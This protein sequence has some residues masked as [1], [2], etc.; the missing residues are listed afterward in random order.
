[1]GGAK[2]HPRIVFDKRFTILVG[3][4]TSRWLV[5]CMGDHLVRCEYATFKCPE[6]TKIPSINTFGSDIQG[7]QGDHVGVSYLL[8]EEMPGRY[9][10]K[11]VLPGFLV[12]MK[13]R[14]VLSRLADIMIELLHYSCDRNG[15]VQY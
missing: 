5:F 10:A 2:Y 1:M 6:N 3:L 15:S 14:Q 11:A 8:M 9:G 4:Y 12:L 7:G 13:L